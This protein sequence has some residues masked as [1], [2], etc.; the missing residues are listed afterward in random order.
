MKHGRSCKRG[1]RR[2]AEALPKAKE[3]YHR[4]KAHLARK[5]DLEEIGDFVPMDSQCVNG[6]EPAS[7]SACGLSSEQVV[8]DDQ[9]TGDGVQATVHVLL[10]HLRVMHVSQRTLLGI[11]QP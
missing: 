4:K 1:K 5:D 8:K 2:L 6:I 7:W 10:V 9:G 11:W 3:L